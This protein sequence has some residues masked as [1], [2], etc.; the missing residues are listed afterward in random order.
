MVE[1]RLTPEFIQWFSGLRDERDQARVQIRLDR[2]QA[3]L[4][5]EVKP[6]GEGVS[7]LNIDNV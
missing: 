1:V 7:E 6:V 2:L 3:G 5:G 4:L